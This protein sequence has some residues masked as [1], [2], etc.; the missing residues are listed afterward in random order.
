M[1]RREFIGVLG[2]AAAWPLLA[3]AQQPAIPVIGFLNSQSAD[4]FARYVAAFRQGLKET[5]YVEGQ[6]VAI[7]YR[8]AEGRYDRLPALAAELVGRH[9]A[10]IAATGG[11]PAA[12][13]AKAATSTIPI[14]FEVGLDP[15]A[16]GLVTSL[17]RPSG[18]VTGVAHKM[19]TLGPKQL[20]MLR[21]LVPTATLIG[22]LVNPRM[23]STGAYSSDIQE[24]AE[25]IRQRLLI[26]NAT[27]ESEIDSAFATLTELR[28]GALVVQS[29]P[30]FN[31]R[32]DQIVTLAARNAVPAIYPARDFVVVG[33]LM[34]Y[35]AGIIDVFRQTGIY[36]GKIL[37]GEKPGDLP[38][39]QEVK[40]ELALNLKT[41]KTLG[42]TFPL[43][44]LGR[45]DEVIE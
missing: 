36:V 40:V 21:E 1:R 13:A 29:E 6:N 42:L 31:S 3:Q 18:N 23:P 37:G 25:A 22:V 30:F 38:V 39:M 2:G 44:L 20:E 34:S 8:W 11:S 14:V 41:A 24:A 43:S 15:V 10:V 19:N 45:A 27:N 9:P 33:G 17:S 7:D 4:T 5:G 12:A 26:L 35:A 28:P 16:A 32:R